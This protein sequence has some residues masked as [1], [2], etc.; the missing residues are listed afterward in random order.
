[1]LVLVLMVVMVAV[2]TA[3]GA[4]DVAG[5]AVILIFVGVV[6]AAGAGLAV[7][8][9][10]LMVVM[11]TVFTAAGAVDVAGQLILFLMGMSTGAGRNALVFLFRYLSAHDDL[12]L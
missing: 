2:F 11:V 4:V 9:L 8:V 1:M 3:A 10:V 12:P 6:M 5:Q 7:L